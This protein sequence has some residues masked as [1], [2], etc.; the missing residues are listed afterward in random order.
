MKTHLAIVLNFVL[1]A[2]IPPVL[3]EADGPDFYQ[4]KG[5]V[6]AQLF[7][8]KTEKSKLVV[9]VPPGT[10]GL[11]NKGCEGGPSFA[12]WQ[13]MN[14][15]EQAK[16]KESIWC[17]VEF[18]GRAGWVKN[19]YLKEGKK[20]TE[21]PT[22]D[23]TAQRPHEIE[24]LICGDEELIALDYKLDAIYKRAL[25]RTKDLQSDSAKNKLKADQRAWIKTRNE[26]WKEIGQ[27]KTCAV[28]SYENR[29]NVLKG[30]LDIG[31]SN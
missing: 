31:T 14:A 29:I 2:L 25:T 30:I 6:S 23:C 10:N 11:K 22:F 13:K 5:K 27:K 1:F 18:F 8:S 17:Q 15:E 28:K 21:R 12:E 9:L 24:M 16:S 3:A 19:K 4:I 7:E 20:I 26:C